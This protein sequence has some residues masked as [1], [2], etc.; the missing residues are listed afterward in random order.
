MHTP[1]PLFKP[2]PLA[3]ETAQQVRTLAYQP[4]CDPQNPQWK[5]RISSWKL[6]S[7]HT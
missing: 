2:K 4:E 5:E 1:C 7:D 3:H 6:F